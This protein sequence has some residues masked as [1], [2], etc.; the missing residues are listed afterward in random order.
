MAKMLL[1]AVTNSI[2]GV[3]KRDLEVQLSTL[4]TIVDIACSMHSLL[5]LDYNIWKERERERSAK[6][7][8]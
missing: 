6:F 3:I 7:V 1:A 4:S 8:D 5:Q 2:P